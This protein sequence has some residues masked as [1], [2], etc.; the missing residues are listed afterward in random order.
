MEQKLFCGFHRY[1]TNRFSIFSENSDLCI[2]LYEAPVDLRT[3][4]SGAVYNLLHSEAFA[5]FATGLQQKVE[6]SNEARVATICFRIAGLDALA[7]AEWLQR[8]HEFNYFWERPSEQFGL[9]AGGA[10]VTFDAQPGS[11]RF[12][13]AEAWFSRWKRRNAVFAEMPHSMHGLIALGGFS[14]AEA[15]NDPRWSDFKHGRLVIPKWVY[16]RDGKNGVVLINRL[17]HP[18]EKASDL[19]TYFA[20]RAST[21]A[22][23]IRTP[24]VRPTPGPGTITVKSD[25]ETDRQRWIASVENVLQ[26]I[27]S[28]KLEKMVLA[29]ML[30]L[31]TNKPF[32]ALAAA[33][34]LREQ[35]PN[36]ATFLISF[37]GNGYFV[38]CSPETL[39]STWFDILRTEAVAGSIA[40]G[41]TAGEDARNE[42]RLLQSAK[43]R[44]EHH[45]VLQQI[46]RQLQ[47][48]AKKLEYTHD[49]EIRKL[50]NVQHLVTPIQAVLKEAASVLSVVGRLH[51]T[52]AV[53]GTPTETALKEIAALES[54]DRGWYAAPVGW[55]CSTGRAEFSVAIRSALV[56]DNEALLFAGCGIVSGSD[57]LLE[58]EET[59]IKLQP[60][61]QALTHA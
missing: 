47:P 51:P 20:E 1:L 54:F 11:D 37:N 2:M 48:L 46:V 27:Q 3:L 22:E 4:A 25:E 32:D 55:L 34:A 38:G 23:R 56:R 53:C 30:R 18:G 16:I 14:F 40:R 5:A 57:P 35:F 59:R 43:D 33:N 15:C 41:R 50:V 36:S 39:A 44:Y 49:P 7:V 8:P 26:K 10:L 58:W 45:L 29:R 28:G 60:M 61:L 24:E 19:F 31:H 52:P 21:F 6:E 9:A 13:A 42:Q 17:M 12:E